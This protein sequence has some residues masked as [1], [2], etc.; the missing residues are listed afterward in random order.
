[1]KQINQDIQTNTIKAFYLLFGKEDYL[2]HQY[3]DKLV[4][5]LAEP[6]DNMNVSVFQGN[7]LNVQELLEIANTLPFFAPQRV[8][9]VENSNLFKKTPENLEKQLEGLPESTY[10]IFV[11]NEVDKRNRLYKWVGKNGYA[12]ELDTPDEKMLLSWIKGLCREEGKTMDDTA[13]FY[14]V[15]HMGTDMLLLR[16]EL[17]KLFCYKL[18]ENTI[19]VEDVQRVCVSQATGKMFAM[20]DAIGMHNQ[21]QALSLYRDLLALKESP[22]GILRMLLRHFN[23]L[24]Q[25]S[26]LSAEGKNNKEMAAACA[27]PPFSVKKYAAQAS[28]YTFEKIQNMVEMCQNTEQHIKSGNIKDLVAVELLIINF[29]STM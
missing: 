9:V 14:F 26:A 22:I 2:K 17:E 8:I 1:M 25:I 19:A 13:I 6:K 15:E 5:A 4:K 10:I 24:M 28:K 3:R 29:S 12:C 21:P 23:I 11:E 16:N 18:Q 7:G 27:I 20:L